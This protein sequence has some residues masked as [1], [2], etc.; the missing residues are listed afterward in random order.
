MAVPKIS[1]PTVRQHREIVKEKLID[2]TERLLREL[3][4]DALSAAAVAGAAGIARNSIYRYVGS[5]D[6]LRLLTLARHVPRW[7]EAIFSRIDDEAPPSV[8][9]RQFLIASV[10][11]SYE[12]S[13]GW[14]M[15]L[16]HMHGRRRMNGGGHADSQRAAVTKDVADIHVMA[17]DFLREQWEELGVDNPRIWVGFTRALLLEAFAQVDAGEDLATI[18]GALGGSV[19]A[20][21]QSAGVPWSGLED[22]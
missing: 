7:R 9:L 1:A 12:S 21:A 22:E 8:R 4:P 11:Q 3:G 20:L 16:M 13:H 15:S 19:R 18:T 14:L 2:A 17:D 10:E 5:V 6:D